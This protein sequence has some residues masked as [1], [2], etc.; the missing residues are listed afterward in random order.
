MLPPSNA[1]CTVEDPADE[2]GEGGGN[3][4]SQIKLP[5]SLSG[6]CD[7]VNHRSLCSFAFSCFWRNM[8]TKYVIVLQMYTSQTETNVLEY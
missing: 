2:G 7:L 6:S 4:N 1:V 3:K 5:T 8:N